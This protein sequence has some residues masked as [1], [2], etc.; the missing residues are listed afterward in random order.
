MVR[1]GL[2]IL[3]IDLKDYENDVY[4]SDGTDGIIDFLVKRLYSSRSQNNYYVEFGVY[5]ESKYNTKILRELDGWNGI[6]MDNWSENHDINLYKHHLTISNIVG[7]FKKYGVPIHFQFLVVD[8]D[9][10]DFYL[11]YEVVKSYDVDIVICEYNASILPDE[12][13]VVVYDDDA[14][15]DMTTDYFGASILSLYNLMST[16]GYSLLYADSTGANL[17]LM[18]THVM[19]KNNLKFKDVNNVGRLYNPPTYGKFNGG[20]MPF[21]SMAKYV[22]STDIMGGVS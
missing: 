11:L 17:Y 15:W 4:T 9:F 21:G 8:V 5:E 13:K 19:H 1:K 10:N 3:I 12:D 20:H 14:Q 18:K 2:K 7:L 6:L 22:R 16:Y